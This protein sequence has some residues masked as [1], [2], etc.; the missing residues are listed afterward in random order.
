MPISFWSL[1][2]FCGWTLGLVGFGIGPYRL[3]K[4]QKRELRVS[5]I[6]SDK[7]HGSERFQRLLR[8][9]VNC[10]EN[11]PVFASLVFLGHA[12]HVQSPAFG[13]LGV[14]VVLFRMGQSIAHIISVRGYWVTARFLCYVGQFASF[15][16][17]G[18]LIAMNAA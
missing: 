14:A 15:I 16:A 9:H 1:L 7:P 5:E 8:A 11:L 3:W 17:M 18:V 6:R 10:T 12:T 13:T 2:A 4:V